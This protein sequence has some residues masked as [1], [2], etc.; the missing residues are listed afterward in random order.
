M[1]SL[2]SQDF[3]PCLFIILV[4]NLNYVFHVLLVDVIFVPV[5]SVENIRVMMSNHYNSWCYFVPNHQSCLTDRAEHKRNL[6]F[7]QHSIPEHLLRRINPL[8]LRS[9][10]RNVG[11]LSSNTQWKRLTGWN[12]LVRWRHLYKKVQMLC[13]STL[14]LLYSMVTGKRCFFTAQY[15]WM[16]TQAIIII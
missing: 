11:F 9:S 8:L 6:P 5:P 3:L 1:E 15:N 10:A 13:Y 7:F 12:L 14:E 4:V 16:I 2:P